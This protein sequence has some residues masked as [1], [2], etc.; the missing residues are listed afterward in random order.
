MTAKPITPE[1][2]FLIQSHALIECIK[3]LGDCEHDPACRKWLETHVFLGGTYKLYNFNCPDGKIF[4]GQGVLLASLYLFLV[5]PHEWQI[6]N[7]LHIDLS[8]AEKIAAKQ[9]KVIDD[10]YKPGTTSHLSHLR[11]ALAHGRV[12]WD[13]TTNEF[14]FNDK[15]PHNSAK[16]F[17]G[18]LSMKGLGELAQA[19]NRSI[20]NY[21]AQI[22]HR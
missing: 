20:H 10:T 6:R 19:L 13:D 7:T 3:Y 21:I 18:H 9:I 5:I 16:K 8:E 2:S 4:G 22:A 12:S 15:D 11:N 1:E 14:S 17:V